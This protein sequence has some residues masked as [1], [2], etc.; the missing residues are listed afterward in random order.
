VDRFVTLGKQRK[1]PGT[2][3]VAW[4]RHDAVGRSF[5]RLP[6]LSL[7]GSSIEAA[8]S[9]RPSRALT[10][11]DRMSHLSFEGACKLLGPN[12]KRLLLEGGVLELEAPEDR[13]GA[14]PPARGARGAWSAERA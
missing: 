2:V 5:A 9:S 10:L 11:R 1:K 8:M 6:S 4:R 3:A 12:G 13:A 7:A 14:R